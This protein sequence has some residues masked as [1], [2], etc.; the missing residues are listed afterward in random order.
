MLIKKEIDILMRLT[1]Q[2]RE[3]FEYL[4]LSLQLDKK[5]EFV[6]LDTFYSF[7]ELLSILGIK[8]KKIEGLNVSVSLS[9]KES[10][11]LK[12]IEYLLNFQVKDIPFYKLKSKN[13]A[14][15]LLYLLKTKG[16]GIMTVNL[17]ELIE[18]YEVQDNKNLQRFGKW[19]DRL[20]SV[21]GDLKGIG[22][23]LLVDPIRKNQTSKVEKIKF[24][25]Y[26]GGVKRDEE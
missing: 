1:P 10:Q 12:A 2:K 23:V 20:D 18:L 16:E 17:N 14:I 6:D 19:K 26:L 11:K 8:N 4:I 13:T 9:E 3:E 7:I 21:I 15:L 22:I 5:M 25:L 24:E